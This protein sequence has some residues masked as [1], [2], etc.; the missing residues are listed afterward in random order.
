MGDGAQIK[1]IKLP[2]AEVI[3]SFAGDPFSSGFHDGDLRDAKFGFPISGICVH[4]ISGQI[5][6]LDPENDAIRIVYPESS[7][8]FPGKVRTLCSLPSPQALCL[9]SKRDILYIATGSPGN[10]PNHQIWKVDLSNGAEFPKAVIV[11]GAGP[12]GHRDSNRNGRESLFHFPQ[13][14]V[15]ISVEEESS[16]KVLLVTDSLNHCIR[17]VDVLNGCTRTVAGIPGQAGYRDDQ[18]R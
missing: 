8:K 5:F 2:N 3:E 10:L 9:D 16:R 18:L 7:R 13:G 4:P 11:S 15:L 1:K 14:L 6:V 17:E 12:T